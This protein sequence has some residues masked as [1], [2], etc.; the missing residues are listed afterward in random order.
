LYHEFTNDQT[1][2]LELD[3]FFTNYDDASKAYAG[4]LK[5]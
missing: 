4:L 2:E 3:L 1:G 5:K